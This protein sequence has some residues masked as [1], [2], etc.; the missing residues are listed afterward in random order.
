MDSKQTFEGRR[1]SAVVVIDPRIEHPGSISTLLGQS[2]GDVT[3]CVVTEPK[4]ESSWVEYLAPISHYPA[5]IQRL[6]GDGGVPHELFV[7]TGKLAIGRRGLSACLIASPYIRILERTISRVSEALGKP[8]PSFASIRMPEVYSHFARSSSLEVR[9]SRVSVQMNSESGKLDLVALS[10]QQPLRSEL[11]EKLDEISTP[12]SIRLDIRYPDISSRIHFD[13][14]GNFWWYLSS[15]RATLN[16]VRILS[17]LS[18]EQLLE[19]TRT[20]PTRK[21]ILE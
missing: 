12:Y 21:A 4:W 20:E 2:G 14:H 1:Y 3:E 10:G 16:P 5:S 15:E 11:R 13:R 17:L 9:A 7:S 8:T 19:S 18:G 6:A